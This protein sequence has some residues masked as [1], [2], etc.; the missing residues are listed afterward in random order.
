MHY[1]FA[2]MYEMNDLHLNGI[3]GVRCMMYGTSLDCPGRKE[4][5][6]MQAVQA[7]YPCHVCVHT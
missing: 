7:Y 3:N 1:D 6:T 5:L 2:A 4:L